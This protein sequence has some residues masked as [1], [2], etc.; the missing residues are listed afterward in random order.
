AE[1]KKAE[2]KKTDKKSDK[3]ANSKKTEPQKT[4]AK[5]SEPKKADKK[6]VSKKADAPKANTSKTVAQKAAPKSSPAKANQSVANKGKSVRDSMLKDAHRYIG[7]PYRWAGTTPRG[8]DCSGYTSYIMQKQGISIPRSS[9]DQFSTLPRGSG[10]R[11]DLVFF[12]K[13]GTRTINHV[14]IYLGNGKMLHAPQTGSHV[15]I[16]DITIPYW[17]QRM[18]G[19][20]DPFG[21]RQ[22]AR[23]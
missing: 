10:K 16:A 6:Q 20:R 3:K 18:A 23:K 8:F 11:G 2:S 12:Y 14:G 22:V 15:K 7:T 13:K 19:Y 1:A 9:R 21:H 17:Q 4:V 5:K